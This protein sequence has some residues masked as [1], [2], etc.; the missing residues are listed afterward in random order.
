MNDVPKFIFNCTD[1]R[2]CCER[3][4]S[5]YLEDMNDWMEHGLLYKVLPHLSIEGE[6]VSLY[7]QLD[8]QTL[9]GKS[10]CVLYDTEKQECTLLDNKPISCRSYPLGYNGKHFIVVDKDC[11][12]LGNGEMTAEKLAAMRETARAE[13]SSKQ[14]TLKLLPMLHAIFIKKFTIESQKAM[15]ELSTEQREELE[16]I[17]S[18]K[19]E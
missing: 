19:K 2:K 14:E 3:D 13:F 15:D 7:I 8:K 5:I 17:L 12:G 16:K 10:I 11:P 4:I 9:D 1:C 6:Y 18:E